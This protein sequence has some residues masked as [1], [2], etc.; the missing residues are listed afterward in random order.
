MLTQTDLKSI[1][2][3]FDKKLDTKLRPIKS[4]I[5]NISTKVNSIEKEVKKVARGLRKTSD[6]L[7]EEHLGFPQPAII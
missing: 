4:D 7:D 1:D 2:G 3:L 5:K 6:F